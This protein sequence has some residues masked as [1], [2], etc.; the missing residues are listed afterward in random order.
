MGRDETNLVIDDDG[1]DG[2]RGRETR[3][4]HTSAAGTALEDGFSGFPRS[5]SPVPRH[6]LDG[7]PC[8]TQ[9]RAIGRL[10]TAAYPVPASPAREDRVRG[11]SSQVAAFLGEISLST[12]R[13]RPTKIDPREELVGVSDAKKSRDCREAGV[14][15]TLLSVRYGWTRSLPVSR[16]FPVGT[17]L[18]SRL[19]S[20]ARGGRSRRRGAGRPAPHRRKFFCVGQFVSGNVS[21]RVLSSH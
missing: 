19:S 6:R 3:K 20:N 17:R 16:P 21:S 15:S 1:D 2:Q 13:L 9:E 12:S 4:G 8:E 10:A 18:S 14:R 5:R 7:R 11:P